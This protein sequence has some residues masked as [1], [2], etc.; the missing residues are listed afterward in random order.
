MFAR[1]VVVALCLA[2]FACGGSDTV[3]PMP[4]SQSG[5][6]TLSGRVA[7]ADTGAPLAGASVTILDGKDAA[8]SAVTDASGSFRLSGLTPGGFTVRVRD[9]GYD[10]AFQGVTFVADM[11]IDVRMKAAQQTLA[12]TWTGSLSFT[13]ANGARQDVA[14]PQLTMV[15]TGDAV[16]STFLTSGPYQGSFT[17]TLSDPSSI[18]STTAIAG[19]MT[20]ILDLSGRP[21]STCR[22]TAAFTGTVNWTQLSIGAPQMALECGTVFTGVTMSFVRQQ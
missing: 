17:G 20:V 2:A 19:T 13:T 10:S 12:G 3:S 4:P 16:S 18:G 6:F 11:A 15:H 5:T 1:N 9:N 21:P 14:V 22:G 7:D 8:K